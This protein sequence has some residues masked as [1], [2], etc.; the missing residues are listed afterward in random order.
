MLYARIISSELE[1]FCID[2]MHF[3]LNEV[4]CTA[5]SKFLAFKF[6]L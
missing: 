3:W 2:Q 5:V 4:L 1:R 6:Q